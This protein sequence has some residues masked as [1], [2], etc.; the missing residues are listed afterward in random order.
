MRA[1]GRK[2]LVSGLS[3][4]HEERVTAAREAWSEAPLGV[5]LPLEAPR[6]AEQERGTKDRSR[7]GSELDEG[8]SPRLAARRSRREEAQVSLEFHP[9]SGRLRSERLV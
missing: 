8:Q 3:R 5:A 1:A 9:R 2:D 4:P 7:E 6:C